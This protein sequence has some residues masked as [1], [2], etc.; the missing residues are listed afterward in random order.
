MG[1][2]SESVVL[3]CSPFAVALLSGIVV[4]R[5]AERDV[6]CI[7]FLTSVIGFTIGLSILAVMPFDVWAS[8]ARSTAQSD[9]RELE[10][11][12]ILRKS[13]AAI[14]WTTTCLCYLFCPVL[15]EFEASGDFT[16][17]A[18]LRTSLRRNVVFYAIYAAVVIF[19]LVWLVIHGAVHGNLQSWCIAASNAWGLLVLT[20]LMG[21]GLVTVPRHLWQLANPEGELRGLYAAMVAKDELRLS[22]LFELQD[23]ICRTRCELGGL[24]AD[25]EEEPMKGAIHTL[26]KTL[27][28]C[29]LMHWELTGETIQSDLSPTSAALSRSVRHSSNVTAIRQLATGHRSLKEA[30]FEARRAACRWN[31]H[32]TRCMLFED[33]EERRFQSAAELMS[34]W[35]P[36][37]LD[38]CCPRARHALRVCWRQA[39]AFWFRSLR[40]K[41]LRTSCYVCALLSIV[42]VLGQ[43]TM[44][45]KRWNLSLLAVLF[46]KDYGPLVTQVFC[47]VPLGYMTYTAYFSIFRLKIAG[48]YGIYSDHNSDMGSILWC[49]SVLA[50][51]AAPLC[52]HFLLLIG[53]RDTSFQAFMGQMNVVPVLGDS[54]NE[55]F[56]C[57]IAFLCCCNIF[58]VY[59]TIVQCLSLGVLEFEWAPETSAQDPGV[60]GKQLVERERRLR[61][62]TAPLEMT[63]RRASEKL[64]PLAVPAG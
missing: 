15:M 60:E 42:V 21:F 14:Y 46:K 37:S 40:A 5:Y 62:E 26:Q 48:W 45:S 55:I 31:R 44:F 23:A 19:A 25:E 52:Y 38:G 20:V 41:V 1:I 17:G 32:V 7:S 33:L 36:G 34:S 10:S 51:L 61:R 39:L 27:E 28:R 47:V 63:G 54:F 3:I 35:R 18:R 11:H 50:R 12:G 13:W 2:S 57:L 59:R 8:I 64:M 43:L 6:N 4:R 30:A 53:V 58:N 24:N 49:A 56:P 9:F 22:R 16:V 29:E